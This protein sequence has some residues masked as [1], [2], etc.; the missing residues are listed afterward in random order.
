LGKPKNF[1]YNLPFIIIYALIDL[2]NYSDFNTVYL[3][4]FAC[5]VVELY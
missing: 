5:V 2:R 1:I 4:L 3:D